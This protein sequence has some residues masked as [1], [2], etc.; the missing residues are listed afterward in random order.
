MNLLR[1][2]MTLGSTSIAMSFHGSVRDLIR[3][4]DAQ[5]E[6]PGGLAKLVAEIHKA[7]AANCAWALSFDTYLATRLRT[8]GRGGFA[9]ARHVKYKKRLR[10]NYPPRMRPSTAAEWRT[11]PAR[12]AS[13]AAH[14]GADRRRSKTG[15]F[16]LENSGAK[17]NSALRAGEDGKSAAQAWSQYKNNKSFNN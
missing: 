4:Y 15:S 16:S 10:A 7:N 8:L 17:Q 9:S 3:L 5:L 14:C 1:A 2:S 13:S 11:G 6:R 12:S